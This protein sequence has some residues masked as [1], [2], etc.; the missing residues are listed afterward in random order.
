MITL[1]G[2]IDILVKQL[3]LVIFVRILI[4]IFAEHIRGSLEME[5]SVFICAYSI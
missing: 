2:V 1:I 5:K 3:I 4:L